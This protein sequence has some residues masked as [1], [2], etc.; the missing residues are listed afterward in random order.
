MKINLRKL[1][2]FRGRKPLWILGLTTFFAIITLGVT[3]LPSISAPVE[4]LLVGDYPSEGFFILPTGDTVTPTLAPG[5]TFEPLSTGLRADGTADANGAVAS[6]ISPDGKTLLVLT[7]GWNRGFRSEANSEVF[8]FPVLD[9]ATGEESDVT[10]TKAEWVFVYDISSGKAVKQQQLNLPNTYNGIAWAPDGQR[11]YVSAGIDDRIYVYRFNGSE[12]V[13]D[14]PFI[15]L[16]HNSNQA[17]PFPVYDGGLLK[18][19]RAAAAAPQQIATGAV[20]AG[21]DISKD[22]R[23]LVAANFENDSI[24]VVD[25]NTRQ[26]LKEIKFFTPGGTVATGEF[27]FDVKIVSNSRGAAVTAFVTSQR[28]DEVLAVNL[29]NGSVTRIAIGTQPNKLLLNKSQTRLYAAN[30]ESDTISIIDTEAN[31]VIKTL[32]VARPG[33]KYKGSIPN[34]LALSPDEN[35]LYVTLAG[36]NAVAVIDLKT[37]K[38]SGRIPTGWWPN[39][40]SVSPNGQTLYVVNAKDNAGPNPSGSRTTEAGLARNTNGRIDYTWALEKAGFSTIPV[41]DRRTLVAL[42]RQVNRNNGFENR[43]QQDAMM[44]FLRGK[45]KH[46]V[47]VIKEN[48]TYDQVL[49]DLPYGNGDPELTLLPEPISPNHHKLATDYVTLDNFY[50]PGESSGVGWNWTV[51][52]NSNDFTEKHQSVL[53]GNAGFSGLTYD[54]E[55]ANRNI[56]LG[57]AAKSSNPSQQTTR[58]T[59]ILDPSGSST[60]LPGSKDVN[61]PVGDGKL[62]TNAVG[63]YL[64]DVALRAGKTVRNYGVFVEGIYGTSQAD[65]TQPDPTNPLYIPISARPFQ[66]RIPQAAGNK[67]V[68]FDK[69]DIYFRG[70]DQKNADIYL[71][72]EWKRDL[73]QN[74]LPNLSFVRFPHDHFGNFSN[75]VAGVNTVESQMADNDYATG[76][77]VETLSKRPE[78]KNT[79]VV[80][81]EDDPQNGPDHVDAHRSIAYLISPYTKRGGELISTRY[82]TLDVLRTIEDVLGIGYMN[83]NDANAKPMS[84]LFTKQANYRPYQAVVPGIL[85]QAPVDPSLVPDCADPNAPKTTA[86]RSRHDAHWWAN[87]T[88]EFYFDEADRLD[89]DAFN[90]V[91]WSGIQ[92]EDVPYPAEPSGADLRHHREQLLARWHQRHHG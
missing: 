15:L 91:L 73:E 62:N 4:D 27:P 57:L 34:S 30:G 6:V 2:P 54:Y 5:S 42:S 76:L 77:L 46:V 66:D 82:T 3:M 53:Y 88:K 21:L 24:S 44:R 51:Q 12:Y 52:G 87:A 74:G 28:D 72:D 25:T 29:A 45:I 83:Q 61:G 49:G 9:P 70:Y 69:T 81:I 33:D 1:K 31:R 75:A 65:A 60:I 90:R 89:A 39:S 56:G 37:G 26:V 79:L 7:S 67:P 68:L 47:Y 63:G 14:A 48:R 10:A 13:P 64:W 41:P 8:A 22:G 40:V 86:V 84:E 78:W 36:E 50:N 85:C 71:F 17:D 23:T 11:F 59:G 38:V 55:G 20:V 18:G 80:I 58:L 92:G 16:G 32:S 35:T 43:G 19:T